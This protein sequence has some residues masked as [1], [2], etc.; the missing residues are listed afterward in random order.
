M[1]CSIGLRRID[2]TGFPVWAALT[3]KFV[4]LKTKVAEHGISTYGNPLHRRTAQGTR[5][6]HTSFRA[7]F[8]YS[9]T[10]FQC[11]KA[12][13]RLSHSFPARHLVQKL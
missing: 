10:L 9:H 8:E 1:H 12:G 11:V 2:L 3:S 13:R 7:A 5:I 6:K 4:L